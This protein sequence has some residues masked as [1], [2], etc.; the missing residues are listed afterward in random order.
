MNA[1]S[2]ISLDKEKELK[3]YIINPNNFIWE[4]KEENDY[5]GK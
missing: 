2:L 1:F 3:D 5:N 4:E